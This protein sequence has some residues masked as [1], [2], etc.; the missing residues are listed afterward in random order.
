M[1]LTEK[2]VPYTGPYGLA[3][4]GLRS[5]GPTPTALKRGMARLGFLPWSDDFDE[6]FNQPLSDALSKWD[7]G[8]AGYAT[9]RWEKIRRAVVPN[10]MAHA[11]EYALDTTAQQLIRDDYLLQHPPPPPVPPIVYP[12]DKDWHSYCGGYLHETG[13][14]SG[15]WAYDFIAAHGT[16]VLAVEAGTVSRT[17]GYDPATGVHGRNHDVF[18]WSIYLRTRYGFHYSTHYGRILVRAGSVV[19]AGDII[20]FVGKWPPHTRIEHTHWGYTN[21]THL[22]ALSKSKIRQV[23]AA[24]RVDGR[25]LRV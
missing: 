3:S 21:F 12:H 18:G 2:Q 1:A 25:E 8:H 14:I 16:P 9:G 23:A 13:G 22:S 24:P 11:G 17:S 7:P 10:G 4:S 15:N 20:G 5:K 6:H 19:R